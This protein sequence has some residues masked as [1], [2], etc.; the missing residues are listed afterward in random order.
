MRRY[1]ERPLPS[2]WPRQTTLRQLFTH[3]LDIFAV[4]RRSFFEW[5]SYFTTAELETEKLQEFCTADGQVPLEASI[6]CLMRSD[7]FR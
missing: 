7:G 1:V 6:E 4:P 3:Y 2:H 5:L